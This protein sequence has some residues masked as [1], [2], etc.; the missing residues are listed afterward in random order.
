MSGKKFEE[1]LK[2]KELKERRKRLEDERK[3]ILEEAEAAKSAGDYQ[4]ASELFMNA[5]QFSKELAEKERMRTFRATAEEMLN[6]EKARREQDQLSEIRKR[7]EVERRRTLANAEIKM[8][9]GSFKEAAT[10]YEEAAALSK[11]MKEEDREKEFL[12]MAKEI[13]AKEFEYRKQWEKDKSKNLKEA[14]LVKVLSAAE[15][16]LDVEGQ[17]DVAATKYIEASKIAKAL[18]NKDLSEK[19]SERAK[20]IREIKKKIDKQRAEQTQ[21]QELETKRRMYEDERSQSIIK[22]EKSMETGNFKEAAKWYEIAGEASSGLGEKAIAQEFKATAKKILET[23]DQLEEE[24][25]EKQRKKPLRLKRRRL[26]AKGKQ[27]IENERYID[28][29]KHFKLAGVISME[30]GEDAKV[31]D[32]VRKVKECMNQEKS[33]KEEVID[34]VMKAFTAIITLRTMEPEVAVDLYEW[35]SEERKQVVIYIWDVGAL[36]IRFSKGKPEIVSGEVLKNVDVKIEG[37]AS[38]I[39]KVA[40][41]KMSPTWAWL[42]G[43]ITISGNS[44]EISHFLKMMIIPTLEREMDELDQKGTK[45]GVICLLFSLIVVTYLPIWPDLLG[46]PDVMEPLIN[47]MNWGVTLQNIF[48]RPIPGIGPGLASMIHP[49]IMANLLLFPMIY[50]VIYST[51]N[52]LTIRKYRISQA[53]EK[54]RIKRRRAMDRAESRTKK[55]E[56]AAAIRLYEEALKLALRSGEDEIAKEIGNK[57]QELFALLPKPT[58]K[59]KGK[60]KGKGGKKRGQTREQY[61]KEVEEAKEETLKIQK[62]MDEC[63]HKAEVA[64]EGQDFISSAKYYAEAANIA[65]NIGDK[66]KVV[67]FSAQAEELKKIADEI[68][69]SRK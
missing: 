41:G 54:L 16:A 61:Q 9:E 19:Y 37:T 48:L 20:E 1:D 68:N 44:N 56:F 69:K 32:L 38:S 7:V 34:R 10:I 17:E 65:K 31:K 4:K 27:Y 66:D 63:V 58:K 45:W 5:A 59:K 33:R 6:L 47:V 25:Q 29:A 21:Q 50:I 14:E 2:R 52:Y 43:Q 24:Y 46:T 28:A 62:Q 15:A 18:G 53:K 22:A 60:G 40:Q 67:Q 39:M 3:N 42:T 13:R 30:M 11:Q 12:A 26:V 36:T 8:K 23:I 51:L 49:L 64:L 55:S 57:I 35:T